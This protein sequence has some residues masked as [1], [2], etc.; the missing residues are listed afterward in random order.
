MGLSVQDH[1]MRVW[2]YRIL[3]WR[4]RFGDF[5]LRVWSAGLEYPGLP[6]IILE[7]ET[8]KQ[9]RPPANEAQNLKEHLVF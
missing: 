2:G 5:I 6:E 1:L 7:D 3:V 8:S 4:S 9:H